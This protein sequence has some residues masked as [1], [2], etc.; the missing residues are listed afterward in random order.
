MTGTLPSSVKGVIVE[1]DM[2]SCEADDGVIVS[3]V[4]CTRKEDAELGGAGMG[5]A[6]AGE[7]EADGT[8]RPPVCVNGEK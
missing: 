3:G 2:R 1:G 7:G 6:A 8:A 4:A 5:D